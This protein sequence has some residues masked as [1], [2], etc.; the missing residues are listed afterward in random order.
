VRRANGIYREIFTCEK[1]LGTLGCWMVRDPHRV[2]RKLVRR[3]LVSPVMI[4]GQA[5]GSSTQR[6]SGVP[7]AFPNGDLS[8]T[9]VT[10]NAFLHK[11]G[12]TIDERSDM[13]YVYSTDIVQRYTGPSRVGAGDRRPT[14]KEIANCADWLEKEIRLVRPQVVILLGR[15]PSQVFGRRYIGSRLMEWGKSYEIKIEGDVVAAFAVPHPS[16][17][18]RDP[19]VVD[20]VYRRVARRAR[21]ILGSDPSLVGRSALSRSVRASGRGTRGE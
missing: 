11:F 1:C 13:P 15:I 10:L 18:R 20:A 14:S 12:H 16:Y 19:E 17:R 6:L 21:Q 7:Y 9:G 8:R 3:A 5:L 4:I 2:P